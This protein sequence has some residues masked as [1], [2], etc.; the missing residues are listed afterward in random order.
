MLCLRL[1][2]TGCECHIIQDQHEALTQHQ[3]N[4]QEITAGGFTLTQTERGEWWWRRRRRWFNTVAVAPRYH[5]PPPPHPSPVTCTLLSAS[6]ALFSARYATGVYAMCYRLVKYLSSLLC[7]LWMAGGCQLP[8]PPSL[9]LSPH[10]PISPAEL[11]LFFLPF[12]RRMPRCHGRS[13]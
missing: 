6:R 10:L 2:R 11:H 8:L 3:N 13:S 12:A 9:S 4:I 5:Y 1:R 7:K